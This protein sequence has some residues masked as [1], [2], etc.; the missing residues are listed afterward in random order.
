MEVPG[1]GPGIAGSTRIPAWIVRGTIALVLLATAASKGAALLQGMEARFLG[2]EGSVATGVVLGVSV[3]EVLT[4][5]L[6]C[7]RRWPAGGILAFSLGCGFA[8]FVSAMFLLGVPLRACGC[9]GRLDMP[10][11]A[12]LMILGGLLLGG[13]FLILQ[14]EAYQE[15]DER[16]E[17]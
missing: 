8:M 11:A 7:T 6:L 1:D 10:V 14:G 13:R 17:G 2:L 15:T 12:H 3:L 4:A 5:V 9:L 16:V